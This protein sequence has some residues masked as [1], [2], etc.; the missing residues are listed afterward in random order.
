[1]SV[2]SFV[3]S[4][5]SDWKYAYDKSDSDE[6]AF[7]VFFTGLGA[8]F[9]GLLVGLVIL[10]AVEVAKAVLPFLV[11]VLLVWGA[12]VRWMDVPAPPLAKKI[13]NYRKQ[14]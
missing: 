2:K 12:T 9:A 8:A 14:S 3:S 11:V 10:L 1:M 5:A 7:M 13:F 4:L 6:K